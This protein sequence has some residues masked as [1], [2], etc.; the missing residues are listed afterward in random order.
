MRRPIALCHW[1]GR[2]WSRSAAAATRAAC[3]A[4]A[5]TTESAASSSS[6]QAAVDAAKP[7]DWILVG[8]GDYKTHLGRAPAG[9]AGLAGRR[10]DHHAAALP[11]RDEPQHGDRRRHQ[12]RL[13]ACSASQ[14]RPEL[15][16]GGHGRHR[17]GST[18]S[19]VW[20]AD[21]VWV[22]NLTACNF[23]GGSAATTGNEIWW[24]GGD[25]SGKIGGWGFYGSYLTATSTFFERR[26]APRPQY[27]IFSS[28]WSGGTWDQTLRQQL[29]RLRLLHRRLPAAVQPDRQPRLGGVQRARLLGLELGRSA[30][31][32]ELAV[33]QQRGRVRHQQP[34][35]RQP[36]AAERRLPEQRHQPDHPHALVLGVHAQLRAR[37]QQPQ[38]PDGR[39]GRRR[40]RSA[41]ACRSRAAATT[42]SWTTASCTTTP[43]A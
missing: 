14:A 20:K 34:E 2:R 28:N 22:Q 26:D 18:G 23:L 15:R 12:A 21:N 7:G 6:I 5:P 38:R 11:A 4:S 17:S 42:R 35:R 19:M 13:A 25:G 32:Q 27:G 39:L 31:R 30:G 29:Q 41:P 16:P 8:P 1:R 9:A 10:A 36:A 43:G 3:C 24:N 37:Q 40:V 33:R